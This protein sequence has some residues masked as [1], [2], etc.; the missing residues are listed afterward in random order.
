VYIYGLIFRPRRMILRMGI[1]SFVVLLLY[2]LGVAGLI[3]I[4]KA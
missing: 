1:D 4:A 3:A 2:V